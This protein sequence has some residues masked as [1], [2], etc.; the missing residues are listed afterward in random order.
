MCAK[1]LFVEGGT[2]PAALA[3]AQVSPAHSVEGGAA[4]L[5]LPV[6]CLQV[7]APVSELISGLEVAQVLE[8]NFLWPFIRKRPWL[9]HGGEVAM[10]ML[11]EL[12]AAPFHTV[13]GTTVVQT[14]SCT[15]LACVVHCAAGTVHASRTAEFSR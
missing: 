13:A 4:V 5:E 1:V 12:L 15:G 7:R 14:V 6:S 10:L 11:P 3:C 9:A 2:V 8:E